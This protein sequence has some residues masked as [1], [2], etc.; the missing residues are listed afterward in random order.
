MAV[1]MTVV[2]VVMMMTV[3]VVRV[4]MSDDIAVFVDMRMAVRI[5]AAAG[6][7]HS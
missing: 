6:S 7:A 2:M 3:L 5:A 1:L 4:R